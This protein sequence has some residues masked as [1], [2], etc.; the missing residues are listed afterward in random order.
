MTDKPWAILIG[1]VLERLR[2]LP[3]ASVHC[4]WTDPPYNIGI[5]YGVTNDKMGGVEFQDWCASWLDECARVLRRDGTIWLLCSDD[6]ADWMALAMS[7]YF[8]KRRRIIWR[9]TFA[10]YQQGNFTCETRHLLYYVTGR[11]FTWNPDGIRIPSKRQEMGDKR[12]NPK[13]RVPGNVW[14]FSRVCGTFN[15]RVDWHPCQVPQAMVE[16][17][18]LATTNP[19][20]VVLDPFSGSGTTG[21][22]AI[23]SGRRYVGIEANPEY[24]E[25]SRK[26][27]DEWHESQTLTRSG[28]QSA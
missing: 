19:G 25:L 3:D 12:A 10:Q 9:E 5:D 22:S 4:V 11:E 1:D 28:L 24:A 17:C 20:D 23:Q 8:N 15:A 27:L 6:M 2:E 26:R 7:R 13:G 16:R 21:L 14:E 18:L